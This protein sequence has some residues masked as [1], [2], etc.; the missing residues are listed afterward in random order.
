MPRGIAIG[1]PVDRRRILS[2]P[3]IGITSLADLGDA[4]DGDLTYR[5]SEGELFLSFISFV[6]FL[7]FLCSQLTVSHPIVGLPARQLMKSQVW[8]F[9]VS[10]RGLLLL[11]RCVVTFLVDWGWVLCC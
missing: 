8:G 2:A 9:P 6:C 4:S 10:G 11:P 3:F 5:P 1:P 7:T